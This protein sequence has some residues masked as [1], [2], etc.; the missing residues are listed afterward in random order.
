MRRE[1]EL[2]AF[3]SDIAPVLLIL[4][5]RD[6]PITPLLHQWS[7]QAMVH[8]IL[9]IKN[10]RV[11]LSHAPEISKDLQVGVEGGRGREGE[12]R[13]IETEEEVTVFFCNFIGSCSFTRT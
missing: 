7:Y 6:D 4:D 2:F 3:N 5:R 1:Q 11:D 9:G 8:E 10:H 12:G 13:E